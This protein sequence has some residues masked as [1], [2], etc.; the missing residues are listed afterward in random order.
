MHRG[1]AFLGHGSSSNNFLNRNEG[2]AFSILCTA[3]SAVALASYT[4]YDPDY[5]S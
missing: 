1:L 3:E 2:R 4:A 5:F